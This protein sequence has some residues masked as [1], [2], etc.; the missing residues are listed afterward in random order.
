MYFYY[1]SSG[2]YSDYHFTLIMTDKKFSRHEFIYL[3]NQAVE[4][5]SQNDESVAEV[6]CD[7]FGFKIVEE[8]L[9]IN[10]GYGDFKPVK[11]EEDLNGD[12]K[13]IDVDY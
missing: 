2:E 7:K 9:E 6:M 11:D 13:W 4:I 12:H 8:E 3:Y 10:S 5:S 1:L